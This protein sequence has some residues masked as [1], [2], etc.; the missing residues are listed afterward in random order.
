MKKLF[1]PILA[2]LLFLTGCSDPLNDGKPRE[3][4]ITVTVPAFGTRSEIADD[5]TA[6]KWATG[7]CIGVATNVVYNYCLGLDASTAGT[8]EG[9]FR[10]TITNGV[11]SVYFP[12]ATSIGSDP[13]SA[14][15]TLPAALT[16]ES[17]KLDMKYNIMLGTHPTG[18][19]KKGYQ[20][21][22]IQ[23]MAIVRFIVKP[24]DFLEGSKL[25]K[26]KFKIPGRG[27]S[28]K[29]SLSRADETAPA[30]FTTPA[31]S[32]VLTIS[33]KPQL[34]AASPVQVVAFVCPSAAAKDSLH[35]KMT[36]DK[37]DV[38]VDITMPDDLKEGSVC[39][40]ELD[41]AALKE[42][43]KVEIPAD[44]PIASSDFIKLLT[45]G[46]Y[47]LSDMN[48]IKTILAYKEGSDQYALYTSG[49]YLYYRIVNLNA[50]YAV[51]VSTP[52]TVVLGTSVSLK[53][54]NVGLSAV[55]QTTQSVQCV[56]LTD[57][58][59][60]FY[61]ADNNLGYVLLRK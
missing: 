54:E 44:S 26:F 11:Q 42:A 55:P 48:Q 38:F 53:S 37:G 36:T 6:V 29:F 31:D 21:A 20:I 2:G 18:T 17:G 45:P 3:V 9:V 58:M 27:V 7:D 16:V 57:T 39:D 33:D 4:A 15:F 51:Y 49:N 59:G 13:A 8:P 34:K 32:L 5:L 50:G 22:L 46:I 61:D 10:G 52:K 41:I 43:G 60:W 30:T 12:Y 56:L 47:D 19:P 14:T 23:K 40:I 35:I 25:D 28:G 1:L 24:N